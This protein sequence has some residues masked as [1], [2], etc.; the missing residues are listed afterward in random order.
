[1]LDLAMRGNEDPTKMMNLLKDDTK[2]LSLKQNIKIA[3][4]ESSV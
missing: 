2:Y 1:M 3:D 4:L